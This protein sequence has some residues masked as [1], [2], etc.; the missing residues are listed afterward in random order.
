[1]LVLVVVVG[2]VLVV[3]VVLVLVV[4]PPSEVEAAG[5]GAGVDAVD[6]P[7]FEPP[8]PAIVAATAIAATAPQSLVVRS[9]ISSLRLPSPAIAGRVRN[10]GER[11]GRFDSGRGRDAGQG[12]FAPHP[13]LPRRHNLRPW[14]WTR[15]A[16]PTAAGRC[17]GA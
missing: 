9:V 8:Q 1:L 2:V 15:W 17:C 3:L 7:S 13:A 16:S 5:L 10:T 4:P 6:P 12:W 11:Q 14:T